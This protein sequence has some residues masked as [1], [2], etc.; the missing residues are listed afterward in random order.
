MDIDVV[1]KY[2][3]IARQHHTQAEI[4]KYLEVDVKTIRRWEAGESKP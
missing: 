2:L 1:L 3:A 4:A